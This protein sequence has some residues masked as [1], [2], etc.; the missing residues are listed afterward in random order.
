M[1]VSDLTAQI[2]TAADAGHKTM[3][4][5]KVEL[6]V[7]NAQREELQSEPIS[8]LVDAGSELTRVPGDVLRRIGVTPRR[9]KTF[10]T[11]T[12]QTIVREVGFAIMRVGEFETV[13]EV[14]FGEPGDMTL[15]GVRT[16]EG[17]SVSVD[18][19]NHRFVPVASIV[20][21]SRTSA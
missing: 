1:S 4:L 5:F 20:A 10:H 13:D 7:T 11:A 2:E 16:L 6:T 8:T 9:K 3:S 19:V 17:F 12:R 18:P 15:L 14:V 21:T